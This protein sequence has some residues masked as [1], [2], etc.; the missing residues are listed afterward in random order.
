MAIIPRKD[1]GGRLR[2]MFSVEPTAQT[3]PYV[4]LL[5]ESVQPEVDVSYFSWWRLYTGWPDIFH[6]HW[7]ESI[8]RGASKRTTAARLL[9]ATV[10]LWSNRLYGVRIVQTVHNVA[11]HESGSWPER[12][13]LRL[14][15]KRVDHYIYLNASRENGLAPSTTVLHGHYRDWYGKHEVEESQR[16]QI[17]YFGQLR[18]YKGIDQLINAFADSSLV[19]DHELAIIGEPRDQQY[20]QELQAIAEGIPSIRLSLGYV[21]DDRLVR[22]ISS[23]SVVALPYRNL[24]N[25]GSMLLALSFNT[26]VIAPQ[27]AAVESYVAEF[28]SAWVKTFTSPLTSKD[29]EQAV[30]DNSSQRMG[31]VD[32]SGRDWSEGG[33]KHVAVYRQLCTAPSRFRL[34]GTRPVWRP[35]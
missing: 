18:R 3:N 25:S 24:Y 23:S 35:R 31:T 30:F 27:S 9:L 10:F 33:K 14:L 28:G 32:F 12:T 20:V 1:R 6:V 5:A 29:L 15:S 13:F 2:V 4:T 7:P 16:R 8:V 22:E 21:D 19:H 11:P 34:P 17:L 26:P